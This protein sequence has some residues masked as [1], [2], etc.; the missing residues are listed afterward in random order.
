MTAAPI[1]TSARKSLPNRRQQAKA[2][3][4]A[5]LVDSARFLFAHV[6]YFNVGIRDVAQRM[7]MSTGAVFNQV[8]D[9]QQLWRLAMGGPP[10]SEALAEEVALLEAQRPG[11]RWSLRRTH[12]GRY[13]AMV[14]ASDNPYST[15]PS[16]AGMG[17]SPAAALRDARIAVDRKDPKGR[18]VL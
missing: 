17:D 15:A 1:A 3:T 4:R 5:R 7:G 10:P 6:G 16:A 11:W 12:D 14:A 9:K 18:A 8:D 2:A 13:A